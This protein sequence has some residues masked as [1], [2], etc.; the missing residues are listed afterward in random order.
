MF[1]TGL[2][3]FVMACVA[4]SWAGITYLIFKLIL[5]FA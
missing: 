4:A 1:S 5:W 2:F 3:V